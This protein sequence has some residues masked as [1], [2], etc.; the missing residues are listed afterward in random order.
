M[1]SNRN[2]TAMTLAIIVMMFS[3]GSIAYANWGDESTRALVAVLTMF[4][5]L[6]IG[7]QIGIESLK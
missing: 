1:K 6:G 5:T 7:Y 4:W 2:S 3:Q